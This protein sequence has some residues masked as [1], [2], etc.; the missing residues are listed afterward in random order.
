MLQSVQHCLTTDADRGGFNVERE[1]AAL[2]ADIERQLDGRPDQRLASGMLEPIRQIPSL[3]V[4]RSHVPDHV[5]GVAQAGLSQSRQVVESRDALRGAF[6][7]A[8]LDRAQLERDAG[9]PL[10]QA[11]VQV[12]SDAGPLRHRGLVLALESSLRLQMPPPLDQRR[13]RGTNPT[14]QEDDKSTE[15]EGLVP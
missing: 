13:R 8:S 5:T 6:R 4:R 15:P 10:E 14:D 9:E 3:Q 1:A 12:L 2:A 11:I 7:E